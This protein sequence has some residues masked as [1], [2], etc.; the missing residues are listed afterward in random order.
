MTGSAPD[1]FVMTRRADRAS[2][3]RAQL[4]LQYLLALES[5]AAESEASALALTAPHGL[6]G[7]TALPASPRAS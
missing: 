7:A 3:S 4:L 6:P 2:V 1:G 5:D